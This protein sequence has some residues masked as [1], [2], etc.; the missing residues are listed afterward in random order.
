MKKHPGLGLI[1]LI[2][3]FIIASFFECPI[4]KKVEIN[5]AGLIMEGDSIKVESSGDYVLTW[6]FTIPDSLWERRIKMFRIRKEA[7]ELFKNVKKI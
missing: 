7:K 6:K 1:L 5:N 4:K 3:I 2:L